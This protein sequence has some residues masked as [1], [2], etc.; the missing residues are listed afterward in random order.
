MSN[1]ELTP[2]E[3]QAFDALLDEMLGK[4]GP[5]DLSR[6]ILMRLEESADEGFVDEHPSG[7]TPIVP[8]RESRTRT[9]GESRS[10]TPV[11]TAVALLAALAALF[12]VA[13]ALQPDHSLD[14]SGI[15]EQDSISDSTN[16][17]LADAS[18]N[19]SKRPDGDGNDAARPGRED[20][21][22][23]RGIPMIVET[24]RQEETQSIA[25]QT[26]PKLI[27]QTP[28]S[29]Q[30]AKLVS[31][32]LDTEL[33]GYWNA[34]G[35]EPSADA[36][37][38]EVVARLK[39]TLGVNVSPEVVADAELLQNELVRRQ[40]AR[41]LASRW[42]E[43]IT[44]NGI[45]RIDANSRDGLI[46]ELTSSFQSKRPFDKTLA[47]WIDGSSKQALS[48]YAALAAGPRHANGSQAMSRRLASLTMNVD[49]RCTRCHDS[50]IKGD[51]TQQDYWGFAA[52][53]QRGISRDADGQL[54]IDAPLKKEK[55]LFYDLPDGRRRV[56]EP[57]VASRWMEM[58]DVGSIEKIGDWSSRL[59]GSPEL[60]RGVVNSLWQLVHGQPLQGRIVDPI[61]APHNEA[62]DQLEEKLT[63]DLLVSQFD[64][65]RTLSL[66]ISSPAT[67][68]AVPEPL[69]PEN[70][71]VSKESDA[72][73]AMNAVDAFA[74]ALPPR[75][76]LSMNQRID[77]SLRAIGAKIDVDGRP[78]VAQVGDSTQKGSVRPAEKSLSADFPARAS[79][80]P[81][82]WLKL[83]EDE[84]SQV[85][86][87]AYLAGMSELPANVHS[88][89]EAMNEA[90][91]D[92]SLLLH[93]VW[94]LVKP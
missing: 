39:A 28:A 31:E 5:P 3:E 78:F 14:E 51:E 16:V 6:Q 54:K 24:P 20:R 65:A 57:G 66:I 15:A 61:S 93:R 71:W 72:K 29:L 50:L 58:D 79:E 67:R 46:N 60:A 49:L 63:Q 64:L 85:D 45:Q 92:R 7:V 75:V 17:D 48:F 33:R 70:A 40:V 21:K 56:A 62:L 80:L 10:K 1:E 84:Q 18:T 59:L 86:H 32:Q 22:P 19:R 41:T 12:A 91:V 81:V 82:Q 55:Q 77:E 88:A 35:I 13:V 23:P 4:S 25:D 94:W 30:A 83:I 52:F 38:D 73:S 11:F 74:A 90:E 8:S 42:L 89:V 34:I 27:P 76:E 43:Q 68:R 47:S 9:N 69:K 37:S 53:L 36:T 44:D 2:I 87:L 26:T